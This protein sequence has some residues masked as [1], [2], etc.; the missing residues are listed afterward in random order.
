LR[1]DERLSSTTL[2]ALSGYVQPEDRARASS[3]GFH[4]H[5]AKPVAAET[6]YATIAALGRTPQ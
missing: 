2:V 6:V 4:V 1:A 3:A 5:L